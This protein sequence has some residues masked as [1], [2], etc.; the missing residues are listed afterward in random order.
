MKKAGFEECASST[1][2]RRVSEW[3][4]IE[5]KPHKKC[6]NC[7]KFLPLTMYY[8]KV[9]VL[10]NGTVYEGQESTCKI[11]RSELNRLNRSILKDSK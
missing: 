9:R 10:A 8:K 3:K 7:G 1:L 6:R 5:R 4:M 2:V 11:C